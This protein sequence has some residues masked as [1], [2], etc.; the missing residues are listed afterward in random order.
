MRS[1][2]FFLIL[3]V[4]CAG[5]AQVQYLD[6]ALALKAYSDEK[7]A[8]TTYVKKYDARFDD[9]W[10]QFQSPDAFKRY[11]RKTGFV[12]AFGEPVFCRQTGD[13]EEC[14]YRRITKPSESPKIYLYFNAHG[15]LVQWNAE[16]L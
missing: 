13:L 15:D 2:L 1:V 12:A 8:Q 6:Q 11:S 4:A 5:C 10:L 14:L 9:M 16:A 3:I 7:D